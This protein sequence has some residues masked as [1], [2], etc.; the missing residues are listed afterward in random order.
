MRDIDIIN[1]R[2]YKYLLIDD[3]LYR[4]DKK[5]EQTTF[6]LLKMLKDNFMTELI[7]GKEQL[8]ELFSIILLKLKNSIE[9]KGIDEQQIEQYKPKKISS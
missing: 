2:E 5:Y 3:V 1:G 8:P 4:C 6:K 9:F 7:F